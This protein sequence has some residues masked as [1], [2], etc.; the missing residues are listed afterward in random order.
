MKFTVSTDDPTQVAVDL[1]AVPTFEEA[2]A[3]QPS[4]AGLDKRLEGLLTKLAAEE[5]FKG[6]KDQTLM[7]HTHGKVGAGRILLIG[8]G[9]RKD[10]SATM[11]RD[12]AARATKAAN[13]VSA[14]TYALVFPQVDSTGLERM[15]QYAAE[16]A[17]LGGYAFDRY[18]SEDRKA[19]TSATEATFLLSETD[20]ARLEQARRALSRGELVSQAIS[21][22]R[23]LVNEPASEMTPRKLADV[24][25][26]VA[27][28][29]HLEIKVLGPK[30]LEKLGTKL[31]LA[32]SQGSD[33]E[34]RLIH[35]TYKPKGKPATN[36]RTVALVGK[37]VTFDSGGLSLKPAK[38][39]E[40]MKTDMAGAAA[41]IAAMGAIGELRPQTEV[42]GIV[43]A[44]ENMPS[45]KA[46]RPGDVVTGLGGK[47]VEILNTD[48]EGRLILAD[49]LAYAGQLKP[50]EI[51]DLA[52]LTGA[53]MVA[54]GPYTAGVMGNNL[55]L[56]ERL[57]ATARLVGEE[58]WH[59]PLVERLRDDL[60]SDIADLKNMGNAYGGAITGGLFLREFV[61]S[62]TPWAHIDIAGPS[63]TDKE[64]GAFTKGGTG[65]GIATLV[66]YLVGR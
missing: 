26:D 20:P 6:K 57:L 14:K 4:T 42:H 53:I 43:M 8:V 55:S 27:Q 2:V 63:S 56:I 41:V 21:L 32:V 15:A 52:T 59:M 47:S 49:G 30:D 29:H 1:L 16:G 10:F 11:I 45:G 60:K 19:K 66:E 65:F 50:T 31:L 34:P 46:I 18:L 35:L 5:R 9:A 3:D 28:K 38:S 25:R 62:E 58:L 40:D 51:I 22:A 24:A 13:R 48:A 39:M 44:T 7:V 37:G 54:L 23:D 17:T 64:Y 36:P 12:L 61:A 33:E